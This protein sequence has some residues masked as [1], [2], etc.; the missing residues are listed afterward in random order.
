MAVL[1]LS[2]RLTSASRDALWPNVLA[3]LAVAIIVSLC[4]IYVLQ[5]VRNESLS[6]GSKTSWVLLILAAGIIAMPVY[7]VKR[8]VGGNVESE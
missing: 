7:Y 5:V 1:P 3:V 4:P 6:I 2:V 8:L